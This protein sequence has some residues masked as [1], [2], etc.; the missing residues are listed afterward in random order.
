MFAPYCS[1]GLFPLKFHLPDHVQ[2]ELE[3]SES[4]S[5]AN[6]APF[7]HFNLLKKQSY[8]MTSRLY[9]M[10]MYETVHNTSRALEGVRRGKSQVHGSG[11][12][13]VSLRKR[14]CVRGCGGCL[15][16]NGVCVSSKQLEEMFES[17]KAALFVEKLFLGVVLAKLR[18]G[19]RQA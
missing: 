6:D 11:F 13:A 16:Q 19:E 17:G 12:G 7:E 5:S 10:G 3:R 4:F 1:F 8:R 18:G 2:R 9:S 15:V 14:K